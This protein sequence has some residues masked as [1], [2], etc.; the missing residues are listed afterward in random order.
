MYSLVLKKQTWEDPHHL[1]PNT[2]TPGDNDPLDACEIGRAIAKPG[3]VKQVKML[4]VL[5]LLDAGE[6][7]WK[8]LVIDIHDPMAA[9]LNGLDDVERWL[10]GL[11]EATR[12]WWRVYRVP[13]GR[14]ANEFLF[15][16]RWKG[17]R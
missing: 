13:D 3:D 15:G 7:D 8:V 16:G 2:H 1:N 6:T 14:G 9:K 10:P 17:R 12:D 11:M 5:G 4:G